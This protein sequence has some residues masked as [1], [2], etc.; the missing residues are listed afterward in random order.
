MAKM[1]LV[2]Y[3][4]QHDEALKT[5]VQKTLDQI[6][7]SKLPE[8]VKQVHATAWTIEVPK[9]SAFFATLLYGVIRID[10]AYVVSQVAEGTD[11]ISS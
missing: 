9:C 1:L 10:R 2:V 6:S 7:S 8:G 3:A 5:V 11:P 4:D